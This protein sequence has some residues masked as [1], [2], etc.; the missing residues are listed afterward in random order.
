M[1]DT[2]V[3]SDALL[4]IVRDGLPQDERVLNS[5]ALTISSIWN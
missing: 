4:V 5:G 1:E 2:Y 3:A